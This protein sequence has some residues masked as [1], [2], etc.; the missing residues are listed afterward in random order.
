MWE[1]WQLAVGQTRNGGFSSMLWIVPVVVI[2]LILLVNSVRIIKEYERGVVLRFGKFHVVKMPGI[3]LILPWIDKMTK[4]SLR[5]TV[6]DVPNQ[7]IITRDNVSAKV[8]AVIYFKVVDP[9]KAFIEVE[10][11]LQA[12]FQIAQTTLRSI[13]GQAKL[14]EL[15]SERDKINSELQTIVDS[16]TEPWGVKVTAVEIK[17]IELTETLIRAMARVAEADRE[18][19]AKII[20]AE[21]EFEAS[22]K[23]AEAAGVLATQPAAMQL[24][25]LQTLVEISAEKNSTIIFPL[26]MDIIRPLMEIMDKMKSE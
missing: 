10:E 25:Y 13:L 22:E 16:L 21:G 24:R 8:N 18:R 23:L 7:E 26:P 1:V 3:R 5:V 20:H 19:K 11:Y 2:A 6:K 4:M 17:D 9:Q 14:D 12:T 15:L